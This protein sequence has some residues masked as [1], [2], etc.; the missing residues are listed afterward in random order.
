[1]EILEVEGWLWGT[2][3]LE[4]IK[5]WGKVKGFIDTQLARGSKR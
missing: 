4:R 5:G 2:F 1:V 3:Q